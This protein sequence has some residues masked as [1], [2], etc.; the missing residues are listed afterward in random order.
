MV[1]WHGP[2]IG[3]FIDDV[4]GSRPRTA[5]GCC[6]TFLRVA[7]ELLYAA[8]RWLSNTKF[9]SPEEHAYALIHFRLLIHLYPSSPSASV[10]FTPQLFPCCPVF[11]CIKPDSSLSSSHCS[12]SHVSRAASIVNLDS[13]DVIELRTCRAR[14]RRRRIRTTTT[15]FPS[16]LQLR[17]LNPKWSLISLPSSRL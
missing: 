1:Q 17:I 2:A 15:A 16:V 14:A 11:P 12:I 3:Q 13:W 5:A 10:S 8:S 4:Q 7:D 6:S 9:A